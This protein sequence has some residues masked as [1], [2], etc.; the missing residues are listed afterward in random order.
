MKLCAGDNKT[1]GRIC[2]FMLINVIFKLLDNSYSY[3]QS[4]EPLP[5]LFLNGLTFLLFF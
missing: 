4:S 3:L 5:I 2:S 1:T